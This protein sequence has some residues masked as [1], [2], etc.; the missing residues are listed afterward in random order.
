[1]NK[2]SILGLPYD[3]K[4]SHLKGTAAAPPLIRDWLNSGVT[5]SFAEGGLDIDN[6]SVK[7]IGDH[8]IKDYFDIEKLVE[9]ELKQERRVFSWGG[10]HSVT[11]PILKAY[12]KFYPDITGMVIDA[13]ADLYDEFNGDPYNHACPFARVMEDELAVR[14]VEIGIRSINPHQRNQAERFGVEMIEMKDYEFSK[15]PEI[16]GPLYLSI[17]LDGIDPAY[18]PGLGTPEP[19]GLTARDVRTAVRTLAP[20]S[21]AFD[22][23]E[24][25]PE[26]DSGQ[27]AMLGAKLMRE[28]IA[29]HAKSSKKA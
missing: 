7:D 19:F 6:D 22:I 20:Y 26:Y 5:N 16:T 12:K 28:F 24:I 3:E 8:E 18:A 21:M 2:I 13:H 15:I 29:S 14:L 25:A 27:T 11:Y 9:E 1:M 17:D 10:D 23:V 4:S